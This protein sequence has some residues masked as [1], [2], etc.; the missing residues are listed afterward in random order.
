MPHDFENFPELTNQQMQVYYFESPHKQI[1]A[2]FRA[3]VVKVID[4]DTIRVLWNERDFD[5]PVR[6]IDTAAAELREGGR[7]SKEWLEKQI[8]NQEV[9]VIIEPARR[10]GKWGR[11]LGRIMFR[12]VDMNEESIRTGHA[13]TWEGRKEITNPDFNKILDTRK[14]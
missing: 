10:L 4:G 1:I 5:F 13:T 3:R 12:G 2:S 14:I 7:E 8:L 6:F 9:D 11:I